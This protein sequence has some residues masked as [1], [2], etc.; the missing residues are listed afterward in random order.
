VTEKRDND[1][2][3]IALTGGIASGKSVVTEMFRE[4]GATVVDTDVVAR[5]VVQ[6][7][8]PALD[9]IVE[10][11]GDGVL[12]PGGGLDRSA[13]R[14]LVFA[15]EAARRDLEAILHP[16]I[17]AET[18]RQAEA[19]ANDGYQI[20]VVPLLVGSRLLE[21]VDRV[22]VVDCD[23]QTQLQRLLARDA[24]SPE[25]ARR[26]L[27]AQATRKQRLAIADDII[28]NDDSLEDTRRQV[29]RLDQRYRRFAAR[30][31]QRCSSG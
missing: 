16:R 29:S 17:G 25:Q 9:D 18:R 15:D 3:R 27:A 2:F 14:K 1:S 13:L 22:L 10:R 28:R 12:L 24:E 26:M 5:E 30:Q 4:L 8:Q 20:I 23:E 21:F 11:F 31:R 19:A 6:P 7:G